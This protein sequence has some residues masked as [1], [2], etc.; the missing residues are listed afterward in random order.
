MSSRSDQFVTYTSSSFVISSN[1]M[2]LSTEHLPQARDSGFEIEPLSRPFLHE[3]VLLED[4]R[5]R[6]DKGHPVRRDDEAR[7]RVRD[8][9]VAPR[10]HSPHPA[11]DPVVVPC[12]SRLLA[13]TTRRWG[14]ERR[15][16][17]RASGKY[18]RPSPPAGGQEGGQEAPRIAARKES[19]PEDAR[20][21]RSAARRSP[22]G[23]ARSVQ[24]PTTRSRPR[25][26]SYPAW[27]RSVRNGGRGPRGR[28]RP[29]R[30]RA[31][32]RTLRRVIRPVRAGAE[33]RVVPIGSV[34]R[35]AR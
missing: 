28:G 3:G 17:G 18:R 7:L 12:P 20:T 22:H 29:A 16:H 19:E 4:Q 35:L 6:P 13:T 10:G 8:E 9:L 24:A 11:D 15:E 34:H 1:G 31:G 27:A 2:S 32:S 5:P 23:L 14:P 21:M 26:T 30:R 25:T 33:A